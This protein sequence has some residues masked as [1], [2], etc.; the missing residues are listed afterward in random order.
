MGQCFRLGFE[1]GFGTGGGDGGEGITLREHFE[2]R[3]WGSSQFLIGFL[4]PYLSTSLRIQ[5]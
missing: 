2:S 4:S 5:S 1:F 3:L